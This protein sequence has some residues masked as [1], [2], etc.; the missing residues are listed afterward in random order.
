MSVSPL[1]HREFS[2]EVPSPRQR[3]ES[4]S[5][6]FRQTLLPPTAQGCGGHTIR[7]TLGFCNVRAQCLLGDFQ[8]PGLAFQG[9]LGELA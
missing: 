1:P 8:D 7:S 3:L 2:R 9:P 6:G 4:G 5:G